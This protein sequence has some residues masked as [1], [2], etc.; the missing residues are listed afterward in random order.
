LAATID[1]FA[2]TINVAGA[3]TGGVAVSTKSPILDAQTV[4][5]RSRLTQQSAPW[6]AALMDARPCRLAADLD[7]HGR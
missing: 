5:P 6:I 3:G 1:R 7:D 4:R 2:A